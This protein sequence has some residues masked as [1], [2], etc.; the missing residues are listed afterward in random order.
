MNSLKITTKII[1]NEETLKIIKKR[2]GIGI[3]CNALAENNA[4][5]SQVAIPAFAIY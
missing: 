1:Q 4:N 2:M 5:A 3:L